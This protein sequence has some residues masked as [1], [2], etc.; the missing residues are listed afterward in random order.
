MR[1]GHYLDP[2]QLFMSVP[3]AI[4]GLLWIITYILIIRCCFRDRA[5]G[6]PMFAICLNITW[7]SWELVACVPAGDAMGLC[8]KPSGGT[9]LLQWAEVAGVGVDVLWFVLDAFLLYQLF[10][11]GRSLEPVEQIRRRWNTCLVGLL[12]FFFFVH[13]GF[14][15]YYDDVFMIVDGWIIN[16]IMSL[17]FLFLLFDRQ[18][19]GLR[20]ISWPAAWTKMVANLFY[21][22]GLTW[23]YMADA[24][25]HLSSPG[26]THA[27]MYVMFAATFVF[28]ATY[29][30][31]LASVR[32]RGG[33]APAHLRPSVV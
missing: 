24:L 20:G 11:F 18:E 27:F 7:E 5:Y 9:Y 17:S 31:L 13:Y 14:V 12:V 16:M 6:L 21:A 22:G 10:R 1:T 19:Q 8:P 26:E 25:E 33:A 29:V 15:T 28:D 4:G 3:L 2:A 32:R 23:I 30:A